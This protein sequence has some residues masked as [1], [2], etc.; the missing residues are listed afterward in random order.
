M[1]ATADISVNTLDKQLVAF[2]DMLQTIDESVQRGIFDKLQ[3]KYKKNNKV[4]AIASKFLSKIEEMESLE[5]DWN[6]EGAPAIN[7]IA[8]ENA[9]YLVNH[10]SN[11]VLESNLKLFPTETGAVSFKLANN[12]GT[13]RLELGD[14]LMSYYVSLSD[15]E[16]EHHSFE[17]WN[18]ENIHTLIESFN[19]L[20]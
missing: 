13:L 7:A 19:K 10:L 3:V 5:E 12:K 18:T 2:W 14:G 4:S 9:R 17:A 8:I 16:A 11:P 20:V 1:L 6:D 15:K